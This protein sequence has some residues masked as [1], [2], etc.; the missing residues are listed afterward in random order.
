MSRFSFVADHAHAFG[1]KRLCRMLGI[2]RSGFYRWRAAAP[3]RAAQIAADVRLAERIRTVHAASG[4]AYGSPRVHAELRAGGLCVNRKR[5]ERL[6]REHRIVGRH[7]RRRVHTTVPDPALSAVP[8]LLER[9]FT[10]PAVDVCWVGDITYLPVGGR[11]MYLATVIDVYSRRLVGYAM[12]EHMRTE[13]VVDAL[14]AAVRIR[15]G[16]VAGVVFH[17]DH[18]GQY[19]SAAFARACEAFGVRRSMGAVGSSAD[20]ALAESFFASLKREVLPAGGWAGLAQA[21]LAVFR[22][23]VFYNMRRRHSALG[24]LSPV[25]FEKRSS[26]L[27]A[28]A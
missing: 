14:A 20:N 28:A 7:H 21:R 10:A 18:G 4:Q 17:S 5:V 6:M 11:W 15:G 8:D 27:A 24:Y 22:W 3:A 12:A 25:E 13:L 23:L 2:S 9:D 26:M 1:V 19:G 16:E